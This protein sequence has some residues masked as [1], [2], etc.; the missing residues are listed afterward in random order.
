MFLPWFN[1]MED[2][3]LNVKTEISGQDQ[4]NSERQ[5]ALIITFSFSGQLKGWWNFYLTEQETRKILN[6]VERDPDANLL[7]MNSWDIS[8]LHSP[9]P[10]PL[11][12][13]PDDT[14][15]LDQETALL[16]SPRESLL[17]DLPLWEICLNQ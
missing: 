6:S 11:I 14:K 9:S 2:V 4:G 12:S 3:S 7:P 15:Y 13:A 10:S 17:P 1:L 8:A 16:Y 5:A